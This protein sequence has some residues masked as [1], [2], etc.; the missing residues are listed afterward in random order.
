MQA[1][2]R[3]P[4]TPP[5]QQ[6]PP[7]DTPRSDGPP[8][9]SPVLPQRPDA[10]TRNQPA[11]RAPPRCPQPRQMSAPRRHTPRSD[12]LGGRGATLPSP[13]PAPAQASSPTPVPQPLR[14]GTQHAGTPPL[15]PPHLADPRYPGTPDPPAAPHPAHHG[16]AHQRPSA[17]ARATP[18][19]H[20]AE[21]PLNHSKSPARHYPQPPGQPGDSH[22]PS[23]RSGCSRR[24][25]RRGIRETL[26][27]HM[28]TRR[29]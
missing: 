5:T 21:A 13:P 22:R 7:Q 2:C 23:G 12:P 16:T 24:S 1:T 18:H 29:G 27:K 19:T 17:Y 3:S 26:I 10:Q 25:V 6:P 8:A 14:V 15:P 4:V 9:G 20:P 11:H 28:A